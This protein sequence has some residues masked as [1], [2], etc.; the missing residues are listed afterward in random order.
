[1]QQENA[2]RL[3]PYLNFNGECEA[4]FKF[5]QQVLGGK[6][7]TMMPFEGTPAANQ[8]PA[9]MRNRIIHAGIRI[10]DT[11]VMGS[12]APPERA[13]QPKGFALSLQ[14]EK[15]AEAERVFDAL[16]E[17]GEIGMPFGKTFFAERFGMLKDRFG[18]PWMILCERES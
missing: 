16:A 11:I 5:Y 13:S 8:V 2:M 3:N 4:A 15:I 17:K 12:D 6:I 9:N 18:V 10:G 1:L 7:E 14:L